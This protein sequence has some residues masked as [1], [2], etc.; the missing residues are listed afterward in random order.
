[1]RA[2]L[3]KRDAADYLRF[4]TVEAAE[5]FLES[6]GVPRLNRGLAGSKGI[7]YRRSDIDIALDKL[8]MQEA[9]PKKKTVK[10]KI[11]TDIFDM[12]LNEAADIILTQNTPRQ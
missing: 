2:L 3:T 1:M 5:R 11:V 12:P 8:E 10:R 9:S 7:L 6:L 4:S